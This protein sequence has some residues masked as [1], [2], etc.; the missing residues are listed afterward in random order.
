MSK[1]ILV[2]HGLAQSGDYFKSKTK[3]L[4][5]ELEKQGYELFYATAP[6]KYSP[7]DIPDDLGDVVT[8]GEE[9]Y[10][11]A[12]I[13]DDLSNKSYSLPQSTIDYLHDYVIENGP[14][15]G[16]IGFSQGAGV[17]GYLMTNFNE[18]LKLTPEEQPSLHF[19]MAFS[20]FRFFPACYQKQYDENPITTPSLH[21]HGE[22][23]TITEPFKVQALYN[24]CT[25]ET[26]TFL[27]HPGGH[28]VP[29]SRGFS[30][31]VIDWLQTIQ[32]V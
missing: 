29:N 14:F 12:W 28:F 3:G 32:T 1:K 18:L 6:N 31:K 24:S 19:F 16:V 20:G 4:R 26:R 17:A 13:E 21:V 23:D 11:L 5:T 7:A 22:L 10:V 2:L 25:P 27:K 30:K 15:E 8:T 9:K